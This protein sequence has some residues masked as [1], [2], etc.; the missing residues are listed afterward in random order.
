MGY[1]LQAGGYRSENFPG[2]VQTQVTGLNNEGVTVGFW[3]NSDN[4]VGKDA[5]FGWVNV[6]GH[7]RNV[8][9]PLVSSSPAIDQN[10]GVNDEGVVVGFYVDAN[11]NTD[12]LL[13]TPQR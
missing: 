1:L 2:S 13:A 4:G 6:D 11:G 7:F 8:D 10:L 3:S 12:G 9:F 5:N